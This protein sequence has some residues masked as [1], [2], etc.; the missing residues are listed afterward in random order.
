[1]KHLIIATVGAALLASPIFASAQAKNFEGFKAELGAGYAQVKTT[2]SGGT[3]TGASAYTTSYTT[4]ADNL[5][6]PLFFLGLGYDYAINDSWLI[7]VG[8][9]YAP[10]NSK[11]GDQSLTVNPLGKTTQG[12]YW[13]NNAYSL[14]VKPSYVIDKDSTVYG[15]VGYTGLSTNVDSASVNLTGM[16][17]AA[18]Y[19]RN[20]DKN[21]YGFAEVAYAKYG[22][23]D[24]PTNFFA[25]TI[26]STA[27]NNGTVSASAMEIKFGI[28]YKF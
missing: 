24:L 12:R 17:F 23:G 11:T 14:F 18:G 16:M 8:G 3:I 10:F 28:G 21:L 4:S 22:D 15:K 13:F 25:S 27:V 26:T 7:G 20:F 6:T 9:T 5:N 19:T 1:M 2:A